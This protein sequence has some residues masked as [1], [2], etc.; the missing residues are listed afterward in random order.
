VVA[1]LAARG[2]VLTLPRSLRYA[3]LLRRLD[4]SRGPA[5][6]ARIDN[7]DG[8][9]IGVH[10]TWLHRDQ[11]EVWRR[12]DRAMRGSVAGGAVRLAPPAETLLVG[13]GLETLLAGMVATGLPGWAALSA[14]GIERLIL[15]RAVRHVIILADN[16]ANA[17]GER[18]AQT[19]AVRWLTEGRR[20]QIA[21][22]A[23]LGTDFNDVLL[24]RTPIA[25]A[26]GVTA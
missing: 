18:A 22:P 23:N 19:A 5:M 25:E 21:L 1:Y 16:D 6:V 9:L 26:R 2:I 10:R 4:G 3:P 17:R 15:P 8:Q 7:I 13:E 14:I 20:V 12:R 24:G 11:I